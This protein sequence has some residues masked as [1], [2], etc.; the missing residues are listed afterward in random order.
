MG[1]LVLIGS[2]WVKFMTF[3][4][5]SPQKLFKNRLISR[6]LVSVLIRVDIFFIFS[7]G[8]IPVQLWCIN[9]GLRRET[10][11]RSHPQLCIAA[12]ASYSEMSYIQIF[13]EITTGVNALGDSF[14]T[15]YALHRM[16][17]YIHSLAHIEC[18]LS[19]IV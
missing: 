17:S 11:V 16:S 13:T 19:Y 18:H 7:S 2:K 5:L 4:G 9:S 15:E 14:V 12:F 10:G 8:E 3:S 1:N 6:W